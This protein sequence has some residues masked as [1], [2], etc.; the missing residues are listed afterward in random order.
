MG[1]RINFG[2]IT[3]FGSD[4]IVNS[5]GRNR[6]VYGMLCEAI[7]NAAQSEELTNYINSLKNN[8]IGD[9]FVTD[10][11]NLACKKI[12]HIVTPFKHMDDNKNTLLEKAYNDLLNKAIELGYKS[13][14]LPFIGSGANGY[15]EH[16]VSE[17]VTKVCGDLALKEHEE[18]R[19]ILDITIVSYVKPRRRREREVRENEY[20]RN[21]NLEYLN[22]K[23][24][25]DCDT[26]ISY[27]SCPPK[28]STKEI[29]IMK[30]YML[31]QKAYSYFKNEDMLLVTCKKPYDFVSRHL[32]EMGIDDREFIIQGVPG[33]V[34]SRWPKR[35]VIEKIN[36]YRIAFISK[37]NFTRLLQFMMINNKQF[38]PN[39]ELDMFMIK[40]FEGKTFYKCHS[41]CEFSLL[42]YKE[43]NH[44]L[45]FDSKGV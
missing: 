23:T 1:Y 2:D 43:C 9:I 10:S 38:S 24:Y 4:L 22:G 33:Y 45:D 13:I 37:M 34:K 36:I 20:Y 18:H 16:E 26:S 40:Y 5:L 25:V 41:L 31:I 15:T 42:C 32:L 6:S 21:V 27:V 35:T 14:T 30:N 11:G 8:K 19:E 28:L 12:L 17:V 44:K 39:D 29:N 3:N 7:L